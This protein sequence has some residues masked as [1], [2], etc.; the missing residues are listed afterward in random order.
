MYGSLVDQDINCRAVGRCTYGAEIDRE[1]L[2]MIPRV[3]P[4]VGSYDARAA[5]P[6]KPL[7]QS[8][9]R[10]FLYA[11]YNVD[12]GAASLKQL[13]FE[14]VEP[15]SVQK[16]DNATPGNID[17]LLAIGTASAAQIKKEHFGTFL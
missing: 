13:G 9:N 5:R 3:G 7:T 2:D 10:Q 12:L 15:K 16:M 11:R 14:K 8:D 1:L 4:N 17:Q 6:A